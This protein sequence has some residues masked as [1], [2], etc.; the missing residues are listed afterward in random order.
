[1]LLPTVRLVT[2][3]RAAF[4]AVPTNPRAVVLSRNRMAVD[5]RNARPGPYFEAALPAS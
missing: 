4:I 2:H 5:N 1:M 3:K